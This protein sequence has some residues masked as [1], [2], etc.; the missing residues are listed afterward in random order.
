MQINI[1]YFFPEEEILPSDVQK[2]LTSISEEMMDLAKHLPDTFSK[3]ENPQRVSVLLKDI[4]ENIHSLR[5]MIFSS[6]KPSNN[7]NFLSLEDPTAGGVQQKQIR[8]DEV[9]TNIDDDTWD[10]TP[11]NL[12][13]HDEENVL[14]NEVKQEDG[15]E[16]RLEDN[17]LKENM[18]RTC[19]MSLDIT[20][21][22]LQVLEQQAQEKN[23]SDV[24]C[25]SPEVLNKRK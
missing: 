3:L 9:F 4:S 19:L 5:K 2:Q 18:E 1:D 15:L 13:T 17:K 16:D 20:E 21:Y 7:F 23:R 6:T 8:K 11:D 24:T 25:K 12:I 10:I 22:E 14:G